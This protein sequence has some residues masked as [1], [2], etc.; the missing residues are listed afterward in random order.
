M[1]IIGSRSRWQLAEAL[2]ISNYPN[3]PENMGIK[4]VISEQQISGISFHT[5]ILNCHS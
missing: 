3:I 4:G 5:A 1:F 2:N